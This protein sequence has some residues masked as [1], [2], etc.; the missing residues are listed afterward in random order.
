MPVLAGLS[1]VFVGITGG[2][3][4]K[5]DKQVQQVV[6]TAH[7]ER[8]NVPQATVRTLARHGEGSRELVSQLH[9][10]G[11]IGG[12][13]V[14]DHGQLSLH[15]VIYD[16]AGA[17][18]SY[19]EISIAGRTLTKDE[20]S[21]L[22]DNIIDE[23]ASLV[24]A[25]SKKL[26]T[27]PAVAAT[28]A[29]AAKLAKAE[30]KPIKTPTKSPRKGALADPFATAEIEMEPTPSAPL[31][32]TT[33]EAA[34]VETA[35][36]STDGAAVSVDEMMAATAGAEVDPLAPTTIA[37]STLSPDSLHLAA[38]LGF[39]VT[40]RNFAPGPATVAAY[41]STPVGSLRAAGHVQPTAR[42]RLDASIERTLSMTT[43]LAAG[44]APTTMSRWE[45]AGSYTLVHGGIDLRANLGLGH[46][47]FSIESIDPARSPDGD[48]S[49]LITGATAALPIGSKLVLEGTLAF[50]PVV[51]GTD[52]T[53]MQF[54]GAS[55]WAVDAG[56]AAEVRPIKHVF[57]RAAFDYQRF[58]WSWDSAGARGQGGAVDAYPSGMLS[59]GAQY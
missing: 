25:E 39:G 31:A 3:A 37:T 57:V 28:P 44:A 49:Y 14:V 54:G 59:L 32:S 52:A 36:A 46:R 42:I 16:G 7:V 23:V 51:G 9:V 12:E 20:L 43:P 21:V 45:V 2:N 4:G 55:R 5:V 24:P 47:A 35:D 40:G 33:H 26:R 22:H 50:E 1:V 41:S 10:D 48:Y 27:Q 29:P 30:K 53:Q 11:V 18:K 8:A 19:N 34:A 6:S 17:M 15:L 38:E 56:V 58:G 13:L